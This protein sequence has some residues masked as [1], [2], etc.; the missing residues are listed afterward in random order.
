MTDQIDIK[1][2][3]EDSTTVKTIQDLEREGRRA[4]RVVR[5]SRI[6]ELISEAVDNV[7]R[8]RSTEVVEAERSQLIESTGREFKKLLAT[9]DGERKKSEE[10]QR[11]AAE[12]EKK[13]LQLQHKLELSEHVHEEDVRLLEQHKE[14]VDQLKEKVELLKTELEQLVQRH[15]GEDEERQQ[16]MEE[17]QSLRS[18]N[19]ELRTELKRELEERRVAAEQAQQAEPAANEDADAL[20]DLVGEVKAIRDSFEKGFGEGGSSVPNSDQQKEMMSQLETAVHSSMDQIVQQL[21]QQF[22]GMPGAVGEQPVEAAQVVLDNLFSDD[23]SNEGIESNLAKIT[24][25]S[26]EGS[27]IGASLQRLKKLHQTG[28]GGSG[29]DS[30]GAPADNDSE[31]SKG[32]N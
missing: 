29:G 20:K 4:V 23:T 14:V 7:I 9:A 32:E 16:L 11:L 10:Q 5:A 24:V 27:G 21:A 22:Q 30:E 26:S 1:K 15:Q 18:E 17:T 13:V 28:I 12:A 6:S 25:E 2:V 8:D 31:V 19:R 3:I